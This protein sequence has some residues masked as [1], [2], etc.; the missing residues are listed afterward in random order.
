LR[1]YRFFQTA[2]ILL[3]AYSAFMPLYAQATEEIKPALYLAIEKNNIA[4]AQAAIASGAD[5]NAIYDQDTMLLWAIRKDRSEIAKLIIQS[6]KIK[7]EGRGASY[8]D[9]N[10]WERTALILAASMGQTEIVSFLLKK[11][12]DV[13]ARDNTLDYPQSR[14]FTA[15]FRAVGRNHIEVA[16]LILAHPKKLT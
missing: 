5:V 12:A 9:F 3:L 1:T 7:L 11:G 4:R 13:N 10:E 15:F 14:G 16:K 6:P 2:V 8:D